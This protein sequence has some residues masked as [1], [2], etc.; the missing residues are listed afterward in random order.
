LTS[1]RLST[2]VSACALFLT[3][4]VSVCAALA[5]PPD[6]AAEAE[7]AN[8]PLRH[9]GLSGALPN[10]RAYEQVSPANKNGYDISAQPGV[11]A[12]DGNRVVFNSKGSFAG[13]PTSLESEG[14]SYL[15]TREADGWH[16][17]GI[18]LPNGI[19]TFG[20]AGYM[21][22][23]PTL[24]RGIISWEEQNTRKPYDPAAP[25]NGNNLYI[26]DNDT[27]AYTLVNRLSSVTNGGFVWG[28]K[29]F[30]HV[31]IN[32]AQ[33]L[34]PDSPCN[35][36]LGE[37]CA[38]EW[39][40]GVLKLASV[41]P[42]RS[43]VKGAVGYD[44]EECNIEHAMSD[45]GSRLF[46]TSQATGSKG[47]LYARSQSAN[48]TLVSASERTIPGG[49][50][51]APA[52]FQA[53]EAAHGDRVIF[54][55][56]D[57]LTDEDSDE[58]ND[59]YLYDF[60]KPAGQ[61]L[62]LLSRDEDP[63]LPVGAAVEEGGAEKCQAVVATSEDLRR[64]YFIAE[65][66]LVAGQPE[67][68]GPKLYLWEDGASGGRLT[69]IATLSPEDVGTVGLTGISKVRNTGVQRTARWSTDGRYLAFLSAAPLTGPSPSGEAEIYL[70]DAVERNLACVTCVAD[71]YPLRG[72]VAFKVNVT[73]FFR[74]INH[75][76][77]NVS[78]AGQV[79]FQTSR[80]LVRGDSNGRIDVYEYEAGHLAL[81]SKGA[82]ATDSMFLDASPSG[83]DV[84]FTTRDQL[85]GWDQDSN[86][87]L[88]DARVD[89]GL[90][91]P[92]PPPSGCEGDACLPAPVIPNDPTPSS[93]NF[94]GAGN[95][96]HRPLQKCRRIHA[97][98]N[99][100]KCRRRRRGRR[101][102]ASTQTATSNHFPAQRIGRDRP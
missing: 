54:T 68:P 98:R 11:A 65:N 93:A 38:Y 20:D 23:T 7:C 64:V 10:C 9:E 101:K 29:D 30:T 12:V 36:G 62:T 79:F 73:G 69:Y 85:V 90:P 60:T 56:R 48:S 58:T 53:A 8:E 5:S 17:E 74:P 14:T 95:V 88:Y 16:T 99:R 22:F 15:A 63:E 26:R 40:N 80:G 1:Q 83:D 78:N 34:T 84:F 51:G 44:G 3:A 94:H 19:F 42:D 66:Q 45:D 27:A 77:Q 86:V 76:P 75:L 67:G 18:S 72:E 61:H 6:A 89:G 28:S 87:D 43:K 70:Y 100:E 24:S 49:I 91:E 102:P 96:A 50:S 2:I 31:A 32:V 59:L 97:K 25:T 47:N 4:S 92:P 21:G 33:A 35:K 81:I 82:S 55:T 13:Q 57:A 46:F 41:L 71:A 52:I 39:H 37:S